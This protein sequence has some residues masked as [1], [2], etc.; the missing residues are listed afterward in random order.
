MH[1]NHGWALGGIGLLVGLL[2]GYVAGQ[3]DGLSQRPVN[4]QLRAVDADLWVQT[5]AEYRA[6]CLQTYRLAAERLS[7]KLAGLNRN[8]SKPPAVIMDLD[9]TVFDNSP[10]QTWLLRYGLA[11]TDARWEVWERDHADEVRLVPGALDFIRAAESA[12]VT[13]CYITNRK[14]R[15]GTIA[16]LKHV[17]IDVKDIDGRLLLATT[18]SDKTARR[19]EVRKRYA[20]LMLLGDNLRDFSEEFRAPK[21]DPADAAGL[22]RAIAERDD[23]VSRGGQKWGDDWFILPNPVYGEWTKLTGDNPL[24][25]LRPSGMPAP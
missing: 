9:E 13:V 18:T 15:D 17:D 4:A 12:G 23:K 25:V 3:N 22:R 21:V 20:V 8:A 1:P 11:Y 24:E 7:Q 14:Y 6:C 2:A 19:E 16:A 10:F 5:A